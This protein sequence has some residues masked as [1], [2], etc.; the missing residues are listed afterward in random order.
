MSRS[1]RTPSV[2]L[3]SFILATSLCPLSRADAEGAIVAETRKGRGV[4]FME[5]RLEWHYLPMSEKHYRQAIEDLDAVQREIELD[6][7]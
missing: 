2:V 6:S 5:D 1:A 4:S 3:P 7:P